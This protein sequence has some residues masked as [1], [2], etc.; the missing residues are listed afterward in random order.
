MNSCIRV[1]IV[2]L[3]LSF[4]ALLVK[5]LEREP[6]MTGEPSL[7]PVAVD[8]STVFRSFYMN[9][10]SNI[11]CDAALIPNLGAEFY[12][13]RNL[14]VGAA[15]YYAWWENDIRHRWDVNGIEINARWWV[16]QQSRIKPLSGH[17]LGFY[18][19]ILV[20]DFEFGNKGY[21][22]GIPGHTI[23]DHPQIGMGIEYGFSLPVSRRL[24]LDFSLGVGYLGGKVYDYKVVD[25]HYVWQSTRRRN[26][27]GPT[28]AEVSLVWL[29]GNGN[30]NIKRAKGGI[31]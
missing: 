15:F 12:V 1:S 6:Y 24:N 16:G 18:T 3:V 9:L 8:G 5:G 28:K 11:L 4:P 30:F 17:H 20:Y 31:R 2:L 21:I 19:Q 23:F 22:G 29:I 26:W 14:S 10:R 7:R 25:S 13:G 27:F